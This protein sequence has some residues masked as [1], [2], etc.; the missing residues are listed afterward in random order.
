MSQ[1]LVI[2][3]LQP[4]PILEG[5]EPHSGK[6]HRRSRPLSC[7]G[8]S[9]SSRLFCVSSTVGAAT[10]AGVIH[11]EAASQIKRRSAGLSSEDLSRRCRNLILLSTSRGADQG[12]SE[13]VKRTMIPI[14]FHYLLSTTDIHFG[15]AFT[16]WP[17]QNSMTGDPPCFY[18]F[19]PPPHFA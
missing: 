1:Y 16:T 8:Y 5:V 9:R 15:L 18:I 4:P 11:S 19:P 2:P 10:E 7:N 13:W 3:G 14:P 12:V 6:C 17:G